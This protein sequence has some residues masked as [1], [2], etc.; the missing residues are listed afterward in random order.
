VPSDLTLTA[1]GADLVLADGDF[2]FA[3]IISN[4]ADMTGGLGGVIVVEY[5]E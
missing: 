2:V 5:T 4:N 3:T 1:T